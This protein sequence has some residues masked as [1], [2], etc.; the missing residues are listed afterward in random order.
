MQS[1][2][3][4]SGS[5]FHEEGVRLSLLAN[6][7]QYFGTHRRYWRHSY[8]DVL[9]NYSSGETVWSKPNGEN[10]RFDSNGNTV[11]FGHSNRYTYGVNVAAGMRGIFA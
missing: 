5:S 4:E 6:P 2:P 11:C 9:I 1:A 8:E 7:Q 3:L 10:I